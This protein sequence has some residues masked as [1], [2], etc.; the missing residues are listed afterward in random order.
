MRHHLTPVRIANIKKQKLTNAGKIIE[1]GKFLCTAV[2]WISAAIIE[3]TM[4]V[5]QKTRNRTIM[6]SAIS[7]LGIYPQ[8]I[9]T[10]KRH[11][12]PTCITAL[13]TVVKMWSQCWYL[14]VHKWKKKMHTYTM[15]YW[16]LF[17]HKS[18]VIYSNMDGTG[19]H[20]DKWNMSRR[21]K[22]NTACSLYM[23]KLISRSR[24]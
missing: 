6:W 12:T 13:F 19:R 18:F 9:S 3:N 2:M 8:E 10:S 17:S 22:K 11:P 4:K 7:L 14:L 5:P 21:R 16:I 1:K 20:Y 15:D 23:W 24:G